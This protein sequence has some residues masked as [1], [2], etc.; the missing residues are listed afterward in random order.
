MSSFLQHIEQTF[1][2]KHMGTKSTF[3]KLVAISY[4]NYIISQLLLL[5]MGIIQKHTSPKTRPHW[6]CNNNGSCVSP[7]H[8]KGKIDLHEGHLVRVCPDGSLK[9]QQRRLRME[10]IREWI[11]WTQCSGICFLSIFILYVMPQQILDS[12]NLP[13][14]YNNIFLILSLDSRNCFPPIMRWFFLG[15][16]GIP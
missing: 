7:I 4:L 1:D 8:F 5:I 10:L 11:P 15:G 3:P 13:T 12:Q 16:G 9:M 6:L 2:F 14:I